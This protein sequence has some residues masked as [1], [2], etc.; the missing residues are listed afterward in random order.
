MV[1]SVSFTTRLSPLGLNLHHSLSLTTHLLSAQTFTPK[2]STIHP[3]THLHPQTSLQQFSGVSIYGH[4]LR[5][6]QRILRRRRDILR[7]RIILRHNPDGLRA[8]LDTY[9]P[10]ILRYL[11]KTRFLR[12]TPEPSSYV[13]HGPTLV[14][15]RPVCQYK[16][17]RPFGRPLTNAMPTFIYSDIFIAICNIYS[18]RCH[19]DAQKCSVHSLL[20]LFLSSPVFSSETVI[21]LNDFPMLQSFDC[22]QFV[23]PGLQFR[24]RSSRSN[25]LHEVLEPTFDNYYKSFAMLLII[26]KELF[27]IFLYLYILV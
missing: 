14:Y 9:V 25:A 17:N 26:Y 24:L 15:M 4:F 13:S 5:H 3:P 1:H 16:A 8:Q 11:M 7:R 27:C 22:V 21:K 6:L 2:P 12:S 18:A 23:D 20:P 19:S 10:R